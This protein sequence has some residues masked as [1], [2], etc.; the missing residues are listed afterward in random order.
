MGPTAAGPES[1]SRRT[2]AAAKRCWWAAHSA[3][4]SS[5]VPVA[6]TERDT[7][8]YVSLRQQPLYLPECSASSPGPLYSSPE[9]SSSLLASDSSEEASEPLSSSAE[10][11]SSSFRAN[12]EAAMKERVAP[13]WLKPTREKKKRGVW[14]WTGK[15]GSQKKGSVDETGCYTNTWPYIRASSR[16]FDQHAQQHRQTWSSRRC[17]GGM[18]LAWTSTQKL[19]VHSI[20]RRL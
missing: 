7:D 20:R 15:K 11:L 6:H 19:N 12:L 1:C 2:T 17:R 8:V 18:F 16:L 5:S 3:I 9:E 10:S 13:N 14:I 4:C